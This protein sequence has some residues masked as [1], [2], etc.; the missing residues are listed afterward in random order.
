MIHFTDH[1]EHGEDAYVGSF[2][3]MNNTYDVYTYTPEGH[4]YGVEET[5]ACIRYGNEGH[6][7]LS[8]GPLSNLNYS[9]TGLYHEARN[10]IGDAHDNK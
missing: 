4:G 2:T 10:L 3:H 7:Y 9:P 1:C 6:E 8:P 5:H